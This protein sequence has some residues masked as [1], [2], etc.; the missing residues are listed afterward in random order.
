MEISDQIQAPTALFEVKEPSTFTGK[1]N[2]LTQGTLCTLGK[3][4]PLLLPAGIPPR[5]LHSRQSIFTDR[6]CRPCGT[7]SC[8]GAVISHALHQAML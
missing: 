5:F 1:E 7:F 6:D 2:V 4:K 3:E 8:C